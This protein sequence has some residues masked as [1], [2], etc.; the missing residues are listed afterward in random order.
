MN[1]EKWI[2]DIIQSGKDIRPMPS[3]PFLATRVEAKLRQLEEN[4]IASKIPLRWVYA[5]A[6]VMVVLLAL[7]IT[8]WSNHVPNPKSTGIQQLMREYGWSNNDLFSMNDS[9]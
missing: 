2:E 3:N 1:T 4:T 7:N 5:T 9:N 6:M 8:L